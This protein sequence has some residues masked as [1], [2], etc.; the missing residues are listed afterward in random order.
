MEALNLGVQ[1]V[2]TQTESAKDYVKESEALKNG[3]RI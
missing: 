2:L 3:K 1:R